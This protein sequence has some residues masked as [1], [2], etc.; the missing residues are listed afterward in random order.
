M[1]SYYHLVSLACCYYSVGYL[2]NS[3]DY[4]SSSQLECFTNVRVFPCILSADG[5]TFGFTRGRDVW[6]YI[7]SE[8]PRLARKCGT[9]R[10]D[11]HVRAL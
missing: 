3:V 9:R 4:S 10:S 11:S 1:Y 2:S 6:V 5:E 7:F 8:A